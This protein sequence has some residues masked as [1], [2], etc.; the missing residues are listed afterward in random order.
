MRGEREGEGV[1]RKGIARV[2]PSLVLL[3]FRTASVPVSFPSRKF[4]EPPVMQ[5][6][7]EDDVK[8]RAVLYSL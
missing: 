6:I 1:G 8:R 4:L 7:S 3:I 5:A 2:T